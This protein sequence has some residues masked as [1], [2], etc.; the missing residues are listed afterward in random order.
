LGDVGLPG[1]FG[2]AA[3]V[4]S[5]VIKVAG[6]ALTGLPLGPV[7][8][9]AGLVTGGLGLLADQKKFDAWKAA[10]LAK[11]FDRSLLPAS[12]D[13]NEAA[14]I[15][16]LSP[17]MSKRLDDAAPNVKTEL[18]RAC[19]A[20]AADGNPKSSTDLAHEI[21]TGGDEFG[22]RDRFATETEL[23]EALEEYRTSAIF[24]RARDELSGQIAISAIAGEPA[25]TV[26]MGD[27]LTGAVALRQDPRAA[28]ALEKIVYTVQALG[29]L[30]L[31]PGTLEGLVQAGLQAGAAMVG[32]TRTA[33]EPRT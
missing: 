21:F 32:T 7:G 11:P 5:S 28:S 15:L 20:P 33:E 22:L 10:L 30:H 2:G 26:A 1:V 18:L 25:A 14:L 6:P 3:S 16:Q 9:V 12:V 31:A 29:A 13:G 23:A 19:I 27:L 4:F 8:I 24:K 17:L